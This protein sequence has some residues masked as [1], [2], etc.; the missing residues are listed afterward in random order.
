M[1]AL[2]RR[3]HRL[4]L[5]VQPYPWQHGALGSEGCWPP[6]SSPHSLGLIA[7]SYALVAGVAMALGVG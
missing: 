1:P 2:R 6:R 4:S 7:M 3:Y 5:P